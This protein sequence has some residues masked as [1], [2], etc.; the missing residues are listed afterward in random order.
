[1]GRTNSKGFYFDAVDNKFDP[2][3]LFFKAVCSAMDIGEA[4]LKPNHFIGLVDRMIPFIN[5]NQLPVIIRGIASNTGSVDF[6]QRLTEQRARNMAQ[7]LQDLGVDPSLLTDVLGIGIT[8][9]TA[10][11]LPAGTTDDNPTG[12]DRFHRGVILTVDI[13]TGAAFV[14]PA[15]PAAL[16]DGQG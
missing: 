4:D 15:L 12:E 3:K 16:D 8:T 13:T 2:N 14:P 10:T 7:A 1:M 5:N 6:N 9:Q 11:I